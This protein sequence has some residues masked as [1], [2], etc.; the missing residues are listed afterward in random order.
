MASS[1]YIFISPNPDDVDKEEYMP[2]MITKGNVKAVRRYE[3]G[4]VT[5]GYEA[6]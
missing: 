6:L 4:M 2:S 3:G 5:N 1:R